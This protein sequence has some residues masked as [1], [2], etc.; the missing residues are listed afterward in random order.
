M[1]PVSWGCIVTGD[2]VEWDSIRLLTPLIVL[3]VSYVNVHVSH[4]CV[5]VLGVRS[6]HA[7]VS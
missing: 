2:L 6:D 3:I 7:A 4:P 1:S 5:S